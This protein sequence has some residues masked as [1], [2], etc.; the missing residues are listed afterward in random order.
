[1]KN[2]RCV[3]IGGRGNTTVTVE[4]HDASAAMKLAQRTVDAEPYRA[5]E[6]WDETGLVSVAVGAMG[7]PSN[8]NIKR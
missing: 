4:A 6:I 5:L 3:F 7:M 8:Q 1:M 2:Y